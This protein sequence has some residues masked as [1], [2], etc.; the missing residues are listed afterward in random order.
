MAG[1][2]LME[3]HLELLTEVIHYLR[4]SSDDFPVVGVNAAWTVVEKLADITYE[5]LTEA[6]DVI[7]LF[8]VSGGQEGHLD[9]DNIG[10]PEVISQI[11]LIPHQIYSFS[12]LRRILS[13]LKSRKSGLLLM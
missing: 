13:R 11:D 3:L 8:A 7:E 1:K 9:V 10:S 2:T 12:R 5:E 6:L 4:P